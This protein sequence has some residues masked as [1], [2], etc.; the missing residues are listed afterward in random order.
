MQ[1]GVKLLSL[2][3]DGTATAT[4]GSLG[5]PHSFTCSGR[6]SNLGILVICIELVYLIID[7]IHRLVQVVELIGRVPCSDKLFTLVKLNSHSQESL[8]LLTKQIRLELLDLIL[9]LIDF[10]EK[11]NVVVHLGSFYNIRIHIR[12]V[13]G[14]KLLNSMLELLLVA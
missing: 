11:L 3:T 1:V 14:K 2:V 5:N 7:G 6:R 8:M 12:H 10:K 4:P 9:A 13:F